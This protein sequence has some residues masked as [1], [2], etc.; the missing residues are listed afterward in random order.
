MRFLLLLVF[1]VLLG[2]SQLKPEM[3]ITSYYNLDSLIT[4]QV[5][6]LS[7]RN[8]RLTKTVSI[9]DSSETRVIQMDSSEWE[10]ELQ[11]FRQLNIN[12]PRLVGGFRVDS[13][14]SRINYLPKK[15]TSSRVEELTI[16]FQ[17]GN[18]SEISGRIFEENDIYE[19]KKNILVVFDNEI[20]ES[21]ALSGY[22]K[23]VLKDSAEFT[24]IGK[25][26]EKNR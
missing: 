17:E 16:I 19:T 24:I 21:Y 3:N 2:C 22:Q 4:Q 18:V 11:F 25:I 5:K 9:N 14:G 15:Q 13:T 1:I 6:V 12:E 8:V 26:E 20:I 7:D 23:I 10:K